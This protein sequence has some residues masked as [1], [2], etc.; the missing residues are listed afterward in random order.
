MCTRVLFIHHERVVDNV[1]ARGLVNTHR[2]YLDTLTKSCCV[3]FE[4]EFFVK[5]V[6]I[7]FCVCV[8]NVMMENQ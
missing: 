3:V 1:I 4:S 8:E 7:I 5:V 2:G 6:F